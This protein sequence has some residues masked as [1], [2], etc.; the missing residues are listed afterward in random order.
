[1]LGALDPEDGLRRPDRV[2]EGR[3]SRWR[4]GVVAEAGAGDLHGALRTAD[5]VDRVEIVEPRRI[6]D[7]PAALEALAR[8]GRHVEVAAPRDARARER[9]V[10]IE[11]GR[12]AGLEPALAAALHDQVLA[13]PFGKRLHVLERAEHAQR[14]PA[15]VRRLRL[16]VLLRR[17]GVAPSRRMDAFHELVVVGLVAPQ[18]V[19]V[20]VDFERDLALARHPGRVALLPGAVALEGDARLAAA[21]R[22]AGRN[23]EIA[24]DRLRAVA[25]HRKF[26]VLAAVHVGQFLARRLHRDRREE[27]LLFVPP[28]VEVLRLLLLGPDGA[29]VH[30][31]AAVEIDALGRLPVRRAGRVPVAPDLLAVRGVA[32]A[33]LEAHEARAVERRRHRA[34]RA[35]RERNGAR[36]GA[37]V[38][39]GA[40]PRDDE[41]RGIE[42]VR[43]VDRLER[44]HDRFA[45]PVGDGVLVVGAALD[46]DG[47]PDVRERRR[48]QESGEKKRKDAVACFRLH[49]RHSATIDSTTQSRMTGACE[50]GYSS[51]VSR[52]SRRQDVIVT[53]TAWRKSRARWLSRAKPQSAAISVIDRLVVERSRLTRSIRSRR[54]V[55]RT[56]A[57][58]LA[59]KRLSR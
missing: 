33:R 48:R 15:E 54:T 19:A 12:P 45:D 43:D 17:E 39:A 23:E 58:S 8:A 34:E 42:P 32:H 11:P 56:V 4:A 55:S 14:H 2:V 41:G 28:A 36:L 20:R 5:V 26:V 53:P 21:R 59:R 25:R 27:R 13:V 24:R 31:G 6:G 18:F 51:G 3:Q 50:G 16:R 49:G 35:G 46:L 30:A 47:V 44:E 57:P 22:S 7:V 38:V 52:C 40:L 1:M 29:D 10:R 9:D 37:A